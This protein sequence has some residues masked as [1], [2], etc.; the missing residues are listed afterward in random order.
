MV[1]SLIFKLFKWYLE[2]TWKLSRGL[3]DTILKFRETCSYSN[4]IDHYCA[5]NSYLAA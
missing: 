2:N 5:T 1:Y 3:R 4:A